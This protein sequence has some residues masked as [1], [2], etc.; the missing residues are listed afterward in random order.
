MREIISILWKGKQV[1][2]ESDF[3]LVSCKTTRAQDY[4]LQ[5]ELLLLSHPVWVTALTDACARG[6]LPLPPFLNVSL[7]LF[8]KSR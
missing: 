8:F 6:W 5:F 4:W 1:Q 7:V 3:P 2:R